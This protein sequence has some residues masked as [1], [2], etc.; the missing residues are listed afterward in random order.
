MKMTE[1]GFF[2]RRVYGIIFGHPLNFSFVEEFLCASAR[3][4]SQKEVEWLTRKKGVQAIFSLTETPI[5]SIWFNSLHYKHIPVKDHTPPT[6]TQLAESVDFI[7]EVS[8]K[9]RTCLTHCAA[10][11]GRTGTILASFF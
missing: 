10:G 1:I 6:L 5:P 9:K 11:K 8:N 4:Y 2:P 7:F 3:P